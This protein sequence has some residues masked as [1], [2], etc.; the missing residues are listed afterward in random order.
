MFRHS[1]RPWFAAIC[2]ACSAATAVW[3]ADKVSFQRQIRPLL[4]D[5]CFACHGRDAEHREGG[6]R[7]DERGAALTGGDSEQA[8]I[9]PGKPDASELVRRIFSADDGERMPPPESKKSLTAAEK[10]LLRRWIAEGAEYQA[11]WAFTAPVR[12]AIPE[13]KD[14]TWPR[15]DIDR[16]ILARLEKEGLAP[17]PEADPTTLLRRLTLDLT[18]LPPSLDDIDRYLPLSPSPPRPLSELRTEGERGREGEWEMEIQRLLASPHYGERWGRIWLDG[19]RYADSDGYEKDKPRFVWAYRDWV[20][21]ALNRDL[22]YNQFIVE[23]IAGDLLPGATQDQI[24]A[25]GFL[26]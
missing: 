1:T 12:P 20:V 2:L 16:F 10:D 21:S 6:L 22:P 23:Q 3:A 11:H 25:T 9:S 14:K 17:S 15:N 18:G 26:R 13:V 24:V 8:A 4:A 5:K 19:A 7:L